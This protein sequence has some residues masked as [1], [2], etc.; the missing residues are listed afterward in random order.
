MQE[1][2]LRIKVNLRGCTRGLYDN[3]SILEVEGRITTPSRAEWGQPA[4]HTGTE[5]CNVNA[6]AARSYVPVQLRL[7]TDPYSKETGS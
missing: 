5:G 6:A 4:E 7:E 3:C 1:S 2:S